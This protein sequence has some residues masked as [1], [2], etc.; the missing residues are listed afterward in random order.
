MAAYLA[1]D[2]YRQQNKVLHR[3]FLDI[4]MSYTENKGFWVPVFR[5]IAGR[6][7]IGSLT[8]MTLG[9]RW[10][11]ITH[12]KR[13]GA[14]V[15]NPRIPAKIRGWKK[16][17]PDRMAGKVVRPVRTIGKKFLL[18]KKIG[19]ILADL[20]LPWGYADGIAKKRFDV[21]LVE[22]LEPED[23]LKVVQ[24]LVIHQKRQQTAGGQQSAV[25]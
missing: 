3:A 13:R 9:E 10:T 20:K 6:N 23:L 18:V 21:D 7:N 1:S 25:K 11:V 12:L 16:N 4:G 2:L 5:E 24:M 19:A 17:D 8:D 22:W 14:D 15:F